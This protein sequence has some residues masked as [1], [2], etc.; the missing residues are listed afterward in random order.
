MGVGLG[1]LSEQRARNVVE[2]YDFIAAKV[3]WCRKARK[4]QGGTC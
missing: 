4:V 1:V 2:L 3:T